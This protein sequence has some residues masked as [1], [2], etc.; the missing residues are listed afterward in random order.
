[1]SAGLKI[2]VVD[3]HKI[4]RIGMVSTL[5]S[6]PYVRHI[7]EAENGLK[8]MEL[9]AAHPVDI[10]FMDVRM[11]VMNGME[12]TAA[13]KKSFPEIK[14]IA[15][16]MFDDQEF[17]SEMFHNGASGYLLKNTDADE[18]RDAIDTVMT[19]ENYFSCDISESM[20]TG[21][22]EKQKAPRLSDGTFVTT[23][24]E[25]QVLRLICRG[26][27]TR[28]IG[29]ELGISPR[30]VDGHRSRLLYKTNS[31]NTAELVN[32]AIRNLLK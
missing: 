14:I 4:F 19:N 22:L 15:L 2:L 18:I 25:K 3:D 12:T 23:E 13:V 17:I 27:N 32:Y 10:I 30:T 8:A 31:R 7:Y 9:I 6:I 26:L 24:R 5:R 28:Q 20:L 1:M 29:E 16:T 21:L 11:P